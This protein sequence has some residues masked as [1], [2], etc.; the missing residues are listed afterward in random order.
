MVEISKYSGDGE[1]R[2]LKD[3]VKVEGREERVEFRG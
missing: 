2:G 1:G 3:R